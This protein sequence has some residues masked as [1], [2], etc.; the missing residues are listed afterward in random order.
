MKMIRFALFAT[1]V[2]SVTTVALPS[3]AETL[4][5]LA[6]GQSLGR[7]LDIPTVPNL[8]D[9]GGYKTQDGATVERGLVYRSDTF[10]PMSAEDKGKLGR[11]NLKN[12]YDLR[13][14][15]EVKVKPDQIPS[16]VEYH[17][18]NV[19]E[20]AKSAAPAQL[21]AL[22]HQPKKANAILGG[23]KIEEKF[24]EGYREFVSLPSAKQS[25]RTLFLSLAD[26][27]KLPAVFH[28]TTGK[29]RTGWAAAALLSLLGVPEETVMEDFLASNKYTL[30]QFKHAIDGFVAGGGDRDIPVAIFGVKREYLEASFDEM[31]KRHGTIEKYFADGLGIDAEGQKAL[32]ELFLK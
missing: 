25:Y 23:G 7:V 19:L 3:F 17:L 30:P 31:E 20:D 2:A 8:R 5:Q 22:M 29:D 32:R 6:A 14:T 18:L 10:N 9:M 24:V 26:Q 11:L 12:V 27:Q 4:P 28:C 15:A 21:E 1:V 16:E 13:T